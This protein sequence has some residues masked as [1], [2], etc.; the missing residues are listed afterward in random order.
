MKILR[1]III[2]II[3][4]AIVTSILACSNEKITVA[5]FHEYKTAPVRV[6][7][8]LNN[9]YN[10]Y[11]LQIKS[12]LEKIQEENKNQ[13]EFAFFNGEGN[14]AIESEIINNMIANRYDLLVLGVVDK[15]ASELVEEAVYKAKQS[16]TPLIFFNINTSKLDSI[17][18]YEKALAINTDSV[19]AGILEGKMIVDLWNNDRKSI[20][21][22][23]DNKLQYVL[24]EGEKESYSSIVR[25]K[26]SISTIND[27][28]IETEELARVT[29][30]W[31]IEIAESAITPLIF[32]Y[33][34]KIEAIISNNDSM[35]IGAVNALQKY[36]FN[37]G[38][39]GK[40]ISVF[41]IGGVSEAQELIKNGYM[42]GTVVQN[43]RLLTEAIYKIGMNLVLGENPLKDTN[44]EF[45]EMGKV[46]FIPFEEDV[47][48]K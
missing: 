43:T 19:Q 47:V 20:D 5:I 3:T 7:V 18:G 38:S 32:K 23:G 45:D 2:S 10:P 46:V 11:N 33:G 9:F 24:I 17:K 40:N 27:A 21:K 42:T 28:G 29:A 34:N 44:Y 13:I 22:N 41:G 39:K 25:S 15:S 8:L 26:Y 4:L 36:G 30:N 48:K 14:I 6:G 12:D 35:A 1:K 31:N 37:K 16:N